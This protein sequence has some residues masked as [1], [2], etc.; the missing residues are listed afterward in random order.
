M[1]NAINVLTRFKQGVVNNVETLV[2]ESLEGNT[3]KRK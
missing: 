2:E 3:N 1:I